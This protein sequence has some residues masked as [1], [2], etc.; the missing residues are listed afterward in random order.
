MAYDTSGH[1]IK[2]PF[3]QISSAHKELG[4]LDYE[5]D[6][7]LFGTHLIPRNPNKKICIVESEKSAIVAALFCPEYLWLAC[8]SANQLNER[9]LKGIK[10]KQV[11]LFP[12]RGQEISWSSKVDA[13]QKQTGCTM[14]VS[15]LLRNLKIACKEDGDDIADLILESIKPTI[16]NTVEVRSEKSSFIERDNAKKEKHSPKLQLLIN[17]NPNLLSFIN[18]L[19]LEET[20]RTSV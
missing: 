9:W 4:L 1:R 8:G 16:T 15:N 7:C 3:P 11:I 12:D 13:L 6:K 10:N 18:K 2:K 20:Q 17:K 19:G 5:Q 14:K